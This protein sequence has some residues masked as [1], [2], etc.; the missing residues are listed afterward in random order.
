[1]VICGGGLVGC[2]IAWYLAELNKRVTI[3]EMLGK[4]AADMEI[5]SRT[6]ILKKLQEH[7]V[8]IIC[9]LKMEEII[10]GK[11]IIGVDKKLARRE[12]E[13]DT[14]VLAM[15]FDPNRAL[16]DA[17]NESYEVYAIGDAKEP[18]RII[19]AIREADHIARFGI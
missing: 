5:G 16:L 4:V 15:G 8:D 13:G 18:R 19:D 17:K 10:S 6:A 11:G 2:E 12:I 3:V 14:V 1:V 7:E 9:N